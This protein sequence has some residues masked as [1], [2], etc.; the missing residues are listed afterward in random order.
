MDAKPKVSH[1]VANKLIHSP[2]EIEAV[3]ACVSSSTATQRTGRA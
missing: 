3:H 2:Q 1:N